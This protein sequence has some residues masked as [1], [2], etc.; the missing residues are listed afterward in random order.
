MNTSMDHL[1][2]KVPAKDWDAH[3]SEERH[4]SQ[5]D[6]SVFLKAKENKVTEAQKKEKNIEFLLKNIEAVQPKKSVPEKR[7]KRKS[8]ESP[9]Y[10][11]EYERNN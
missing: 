1:E 6:R 7:Q 10:R 9:H 3:L 5:R 4:I 8:F 11:E 2:L